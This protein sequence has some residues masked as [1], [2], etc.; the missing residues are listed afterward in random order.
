MKLV[1][2]ENEYLEYL[3]KDRSNVLK[4]S[5]RVY[6]VEFDI[7]GKNYVIPLTSQ[8][9][10]NVSD[11]YKVIL[12]ERGQVIGNVLTNNAIPLKSLNYIKEYVDIDLLDENSIT[13]RQYN[14]LIKKENEIKEK[15]NYAINNCLDKSDFYLYSKEL[16]E[17]ALNANI[18]K[19]DNLTEDEYLLKDITNKYNQF[20]LLDNEKNNALKYLEKRGITYETIEKFK[21]GYAPQFF[22]NQIEQFITTQTI[23]HKK[24]SLYEFDKSG[25]MNK[26]NSQFFKER[27]IIPIM[28]ENG[29]VK[30]FSGRQIIDNEKF[31]KYMNSAESNVFKKRELLFNLNNA[32]K[33][34]EVILCEGFFDV[35]SLDQVGIKN[36]VC[37]MGTKL[38]HEHLM[39]LKKNNI[40]KV[41][42]LLDNDI[43]GREATIDIINTLNKYQIDS[44]VINLPDNIN[45]I[46][47]FIQSGGNINALK[48]E[49]SSIFLKNQELQEVTQANITEGTYIF[50][51]EKVEAELNRIKNLNISKK[52][53]EQIF[54]RNSDNNIVIE[55][56]DK[57]PLF[58]HNKVKIVGYVSNKK[59]DFSYTKNNVAY[60]NNVAIN[61]FAGKDWEGKVKYHTIF[62][63]IYGES[64]QKLKKLHDAGFRK[65]VEFNGTIKMNEYIT[66]SGEQKSM[67]VF[68][69]YNINE[70]HE[71]KQQTLVDIAG[72]LTKKEIYEMEN[73][74]IKADIIITDRY[75]DKNEKTVFR[76]NKVTL[77]DKE[78]DIINDVELYQDLSLKGKFIYDATTKQMRIC[79]TELE[80]G[81]TKSERDL[82]YSKK[83]EE[84]VC[85]E[86][87]HKEN[88]EEN[89][90]EIKSVKQFADPDLDIE[91][92]R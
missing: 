40:N 73:G 60:L 16:E 52:D 70:N 31:P 84:K 11:K 71:Q 90:V 67:E 36:A 45:D 17:K 92:D 5:K 69:V 48:K 29:I 41:S 13:K 79:C 10:L 77:F 6:M 22:D 80:P 4:G 50:D 14:S 62:T 54:E 26:I 7:N 28:D 8:N 85:G 34:N 91:L 27:I 64:A 24:Y 51:R 15:L 83:Q 1:R 9:K 39:K 21:L 78:V 3:L 55:N 18:D 2:L 66:K 63:D 42:I 44:E 57:K 58:N 46:D 86:I 74:S 37:L 81:L 76:N 30:G 53:I 19:Y 68:N 32:K 20:L 49:H 23:N 59:L 38:S 25:I 56:T 87:T 12:E 75:K 33:Y 35:I 47:E 43:A 65:P 61:V 72:M 88:H 89:K 82:Y